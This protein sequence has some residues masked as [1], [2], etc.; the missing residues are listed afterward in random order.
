MW[1]RLEARRSVL[2]HAPRFS[3]GRL[4]ARSFRDAWNRRS[5]CRSVEIHMPSVIR[6]HQLDL[7][8]LAATLNDHAGIDLPAEVVEGG[9]HDFFDALAEEL[10]RQPGSTLVVIRGGH[11]GEEEPRYALIAEFCDLISSFGDIQAGEVTLLVLDDYSMYFY[12]NWRNEVSR[13]DFLAPL[14]LRLI[15]SRELERFLVGVD[16]LSEDDARL[17]AHRLLLLTGGHHGLILELLENLGLQLRPAERNQAFDYAALTADHR[18]EDLESLLD[19][20]RILDE[21]QR[22]LAGQARIFCPEALHHLKPRLFPPKTPDRQY[23]TE[24]GVLARSGINRLM[25][26]PG[27]IQH[28]VEEMGTTIGQKGGSPIFDSTDGSLPAM[29]ELETDLG[30]AQIDD[31]D[32][33]VV[34]ISDLHVGPEFRFYLT[35][36][37]FEGRKKAEV[38]LRQDLEQLGILDRV[39]ALVVSGDFVEVGTDFALFQR[40]YEVVEA[41]RK[42]LNLDPSRVAVVAGNHDVDWTPSEYA[43]VRPETKV[44]RDNFDGFCRMLGKETGQASLVQVPSRGGGA[45]LR[46]LGLDSN[47]VEGPDAGG[48]GFVGSKA[49]ELADELLRRDDLE[50]DDENIDVLTW[51][52]VHHHLFPATS[53]GA[54][55]ALGKRIS[56]FADASELLYHAR[57]WRA[58]L[59]LHGHEHQPS[60]T[61]AHRWSYPPRGRGDQVFYPVISAGAGSFSLGSHLGPIGRNQYYI[62]H[63]KKHEACFYSRILDAHGVAFTHHDQV[64]VDLKSF[65]GG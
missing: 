19:G 5:G 33:V 65:G 12:E 58:E 2:V 54:G 20:S 41:I 15:R 6:R 8:Q 56:T 22:L 11:Q 31:D 55:E 53:P 45:R 25:L 37:D 59:V 18:L 51:I 21:L 29:G 16:P 7:V 49:T 57:R 24:L 63:R 17:A 34:H 36:R 39:D 4:F 52:V 62:V 10:K 40:A 46:F 61:V 26:C 47:L 38:L 50:V 9:R 23:L 43:D 64:R 27:M 32:F 1:S 3:G 13:F 30:Q 60:I 35:T 42:S 48:I 14:C 28:L 44:S